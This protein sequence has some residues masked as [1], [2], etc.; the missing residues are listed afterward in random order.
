MGSAPSPHPRGD[1]RCSAYVGV[2]PL[3]G[4]GGGIGGFGNW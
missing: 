2:F 1:P 3:I 4:I